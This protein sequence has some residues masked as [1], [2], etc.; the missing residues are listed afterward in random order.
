M[1]GRIPE[2][3]SMFTNIVLVPICLRTGTRTDYVISA[4]AEGRWRELVREKVQYIPG[5][6][7]GDDLPPELVTQ[8]IASIYAHAEAKSRRLSIQSLSLTSKYITQVAEPFRFRA[9]S[10]SPQNAT[11]L[12]YVFE[13]RPALQQYVHSLWI[14]DTVPERKSPLHPIPPYRTPVCVP[15]RKELGLDQ[16]QPNLGPR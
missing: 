11:A 16:D 5:T 14:R 13:T 6:H 7:S 10:V 8:I 2:K 12:L 4:T 9:I 3:V 15:M 1:K